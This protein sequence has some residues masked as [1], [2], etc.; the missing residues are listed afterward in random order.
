MA[1]APPITAISF[2][3]LSSLIEIG[4]KASNYRERTD[5]MLRRVISVF[6]AAVTLLFVGMLTISSTTAPASAAQ[7]PHEVCDWSTTINAPQMNGESTTVV[8]T[9]DFGRTGPY[10]L[11]S[12]LGNKPPA[13]WD[14]TDAYQYSGTYTGQFVDFYLTNALTGNQFAGSF[15]V[16]IQYFPFTSGSAC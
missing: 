5:R 12:S 11:N 2:G 1:P 6:V 3:Y 13:P 16:K 4:H 7:G 14:S 15:N 9:F 10:M 8:T